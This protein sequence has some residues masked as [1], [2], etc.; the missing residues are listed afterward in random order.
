[1]ARTG[2]AAS[3]SDRYVAARDFT[4]IARA[5]DHAVREG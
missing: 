4:P 3:R 2:R 1:L 5:A